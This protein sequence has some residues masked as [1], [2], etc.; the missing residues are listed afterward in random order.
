MSGMR[1]LTLP[2][3][4]ALALAGVAAMVYMTPKGPGIYY[5]SVIYVDSARNLLLGKGY[6]STLAVSSK[7]NLTHGERPLTCFPPLFPLILALI[8]L[9]GPDPMN[10][11]G[12]LN[13][14][15]F[16][17][18]IL[19]VG[20]ALRKYTRGSFYTSVLGSFLML[21]SATMLSV[22]S[23]A[24]TEPLFLFLGTLG[25]LLVMRYLR[26]GS[27]WALVAGSVAMAL[28]FLTRYVGGALIVTGLVGI[29]FVGSQAFSRRVMDGLIFL[30]VSVFPMGL[31]LM[32]NIY[33]AGDATGRS[34]SFHPVVADFFKVLFITM[35]SWIFPGS[36]KVILFPGQDIFTGLILVV[37]LT[38]LIFS[39]VVL[40]HHKVEREE[41]KGIKEY[42]R[43]T[44]FLLLTFIGI[45]LLLLFLSIC[46]FDPSTR[47][48]ERHTSCLFMAGLILV[49][50]LLHRTYHFS[51]RRGLRLGLITV[52]TVFAAGYLS[53]AIMCTVSYHKYGRGLTGKRW[54]V[55]RMISEKIRRDMPEVTVF[56]TGP[57]SACAFFFFTGTPAYALTELIKDSIKVS[58]YLGGHEGVWIHF[59]ISLRKGS[60]Y[61][62]AWFHPGLSEQQV[63]RYFLSHHLSPRLL[64]EK[65]GLFL[66]QVG[67]NE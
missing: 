60:R 65:E 38:G 45:C 66:F 40:F 12:G 67:S 4:I 5:D 33:M 61:K 13:A 3:L 30:V 55:F 34:F 59:R 51:K 1:A 14:F 25:I 6:V 22:H 43:N 48:N 8:G 58:D 18:N 56:T 23:I 52:S 27:R 16:G 11:A 21:T 37:I 36:N 35:G 41:G 63:Q 17:L 44:P 39:G 7:V 20:L 29:L 49:L 26:N 50:Y 10:G 32:R 62:Q 64:Q 9:W 31:F 2:V 15:L 19:L 28:A 42:L 24:Q 57:I 54:E 53:A 46:F 47:P